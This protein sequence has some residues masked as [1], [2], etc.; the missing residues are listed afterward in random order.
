[1]SK[2]K[3]RSYGGCAI[4]KISPAI[5]PNPKIINVIVS[6]PEAL[7]LKLAIEECLRR[8]NKYNLSTKAGKRAA[9]NVAIHVHAD[10]IAILEDKLPK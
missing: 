2:E 5:L 3:T 8:L 10:R 7:K 9:L 1:M 6:F 4:A